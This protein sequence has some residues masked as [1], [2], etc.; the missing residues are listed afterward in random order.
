AYPSDPIV[1]SALAEAEFDAGNHAA[2]LAA[3]DRALAA[4]PNTPQA[5]ITKG[6]AL[7]ELAAAD[8]GEA[9][10]K[11]IRGLFGRAN[12]LDTE[13]AEPLM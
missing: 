6:R 10:W 3:A 1:Q 2:A 5:L 8:P 4:K 11:T 13:D 7:M 9:D 12:R